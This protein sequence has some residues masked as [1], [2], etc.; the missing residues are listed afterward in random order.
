MT[1]AKNVVYAEIDRISTEL[2]ELSTDVSN[3]LQSTY[4]KDIIYT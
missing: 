4:L 2:R 1:E 3:T